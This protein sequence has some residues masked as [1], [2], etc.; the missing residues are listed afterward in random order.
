MLRETLLVLEEAQRLK[1]QAKVAEQRA[2]QLLAPQDVPTNVE[3]HN[4]ATKTEV[5]TNPLS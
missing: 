2:K 4:L 5:E 1:A 3:V